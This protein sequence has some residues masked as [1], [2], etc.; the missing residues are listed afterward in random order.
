VRRAAA[1]LV[2]GLVAFVLAGWGAGELWISISGSADLTAEK[3]VADNRSAAL[4][5]VAK[6]IT[7]A[8]SSVVLIPLTVI[9]GLLLLRAGHRSEAV[10]LA[11]SLG[12]AIVIW[13]AVKALVGRPRPPLEHLQH[14][15]GSSFPSGHSA[16]AGAFW[17]GLV[18]ALRSA[19]APRRIVMAA[20]VVAC[21][22]VVCVAASRVILSVH[23][24]SDVVAGVAIGAGWALFTF[25]TVRGVTDR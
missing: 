9:C 15:S 11:L 3:W 7:W 2:L 17:L 20:A 14:V 21:V 22:L 8:G 19:H 4:V 6:V 13:H 12:G 10:A 16:Q 1:R 18:L 23:Y 24:P 25:W 5:D